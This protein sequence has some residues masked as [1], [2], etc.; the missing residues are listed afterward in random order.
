M[1]QYHDALVLVSILGLVFTA[2]QWDR[3]SYELE[4]QAQRQL[5]TTQSSC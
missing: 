2:V 5:A 1:S 3:P 4:A